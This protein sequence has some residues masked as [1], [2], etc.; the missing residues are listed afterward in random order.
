MVRDQL[1]EHRT[2]L[3]PVAAGGWNAM[4]KSITDRIKSTPASSE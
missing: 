2:R 3:G 4:E 1:D